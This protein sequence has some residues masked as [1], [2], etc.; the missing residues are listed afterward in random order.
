VERTVCAAEGI[1][2]AT[3][4]VGAVI[5]SAVVNTAGSG[6]TATAPG[7]TATQTSIALTTTEPT[8]TS[9]SGAAVVGRGGSAV[10]MLAA[11]LALLFI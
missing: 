9:R 11:L 8:G 2:T 7:S 3:T 4:S 5:S 1:F 10:V 6:A